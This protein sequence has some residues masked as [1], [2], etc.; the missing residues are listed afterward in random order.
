CGTSILFYHEPASGRVW[1]YR[2]AGGR[3]WVAGNTLAYRKSWWAR[4]PFPEVQVS[5]D[6]RFVWTA[7]SDKVCDLRHPRL[8][9]ARIHNGNTSRKT[10]QGACWELCGAAELQE[11]L[12]DEWPLFSGEVSA[13]PTQSD[14]PLVSC[15]MPTRNRRSFL[16]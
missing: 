4:H 9:V 6:S 1:R 13:T 3:A 2:F 8:C 10:P 16:P 5:E 7:P 15:I 11:T 12:G 14:T